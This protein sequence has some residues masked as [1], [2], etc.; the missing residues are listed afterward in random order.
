MSS[1][2]GPTMNE[3]NGKEN[4]ATQP[5]QALEPLRAPLP[6]L[7]VPNDAEARKALTELGLVQMPQDCLRTLAV[8]GAY[9]EGVG[10]LKTQRGHT[11]VNQQWLM[12]QMRAV[13]EMTRQVVSNPDP[14]FKLQARCE[15]VGML[16]RAQAQLASKMTE[17][18]TMA[19]ENEREAIERGVQEMV[20][21]ADFVPGAI[22]RPAAKS[23]Q[24]LIQAE[25]VHFHGPG[26][27]TKPS[28][29]AT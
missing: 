23:N 3:P 7:R 9:A 5:S 24:T 8:V 11:V 4:G 17:A 10:L 15:I 21:A 13:G 14:K 1:T 22:I 12:E 6:A 25:T 20:P 29:P 2:T 28:D 16:S 18:G 27:E 19:I 26:S